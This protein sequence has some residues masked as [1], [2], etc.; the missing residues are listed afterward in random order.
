LLSKLSDNKLLNVQAPKSFLIFISL[1]LIYIFNISLTQSAAEDPTNIEALKNEY[2]T[3]LKKFEGAYGKGISPN[4]LSF[5]QAMH[6]FRLRPW[7]SNRNASDLG[8]LTYNPAAVAQKMGLIR[9]KG[10][11]RFPA[12]DGKHYTEWQTST[13]S[14]EYLDLLAEAAVKKRAYPWSESYLNQPHLK[15]KLQAKG[16]KESNNFDF[17]V[18]FSIHS[19]IMDGSGSKTKT[20]CGGIGQFETCHAADGYYK[21]KLKALKELSVYFKSL[22]KDNNH[23]IDPF[24][25]AVKIERAFIQLHPFIDGNGRTAMALLYLVLRPLSLPVP[26]IENGY[27]DTNVDINTHVKSLV[28][29]QENSIKVIGACADYLYCAEKHS[30]FKAGDWNS[31]CE[32]SPEKSECSSYLPELK[33][34]VSAQVYKLAPCDCSLR[35]K[36]QKELFSA[37]KESGRK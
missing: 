9:N 17:D 7:Y 33:V 16:K 37:C 28:E 36:L 35:W 30:Y 26:S 31:M 1:F 12:S 22:S 29:A 2:S 18:L 32:I 15:E 25:L 6:F 10:L 23:T 13:R 14:F 20:E 5:L 27:L 4:D 24:F 34:A 11:C 8:S 21:D 19:A 3:A